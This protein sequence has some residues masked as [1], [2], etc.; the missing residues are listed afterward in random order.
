[1]KAMK[2]KG[3]L[4]AALA[5]ILALGAVLSACS[6]KEEGS[7]APSAG[8]NPSA[9]APAAPVKRGSITSSAYD[10]GTVPA[11]EGTMENNR[12]TR[13]LNENGPVDVKF[14]AIPRFDS[15]QKYNTLFASGS[16]PDLIFEYDSSY[17]RQ[18]YEQK[19]LLPLDDLIP[20][21]APN[22]N[23]FLEQYPVLKKLGTKSDGKL[24]ELG[25]VSSIRPN[26]VLFIRGDWLKKLNLEVP[27]T[28]EELFSVAKAFATQDPDG[29]GKQDTYGFSLSFVSGMVL[30]FMFGNVFTIYEKYPWYVKDGELLHD[31]ERSAAA[32]AYK[33]KIYDEGLVDKDFLTDTK[34]EK[35]KQDWINGKLGIYGANSGL[36]DK[37]T[38]Q[39]LKKLNPQAELI[40]IALPKTSIGQFAPMFPS[41]I[42]NTAVVNAKAKDPAAVLAYVD[43]LIQEP[44]A[45]T[46]SNGIKGVHYET[47]STGCP[48]PIDIEKNKIEANYQYD[49]TLLSSLEVLNPKCSGLEAYFDPLVLNKTEVEKEFYALRKPA[50]EAYVSKERQL[51]LYTMIDFMPALPQDLQL[52]T[53]NA[54]KTIQDTWVKAIVGGKGYTVDQAV[55]DAQGA[56]EKASGGKVDDW[57]KQWYKENKD[58]AIFTKDIYD[59][60]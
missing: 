30:D 56:W 26:H 60:K 28:D 10:R 9:S 31:W 35:A 39:A 48:Q 8:G 50:Y 44:A 13:W 47:E 15:I 20:K 14:V 3:T 2:T 24:Y 49:L 6:A 52:L 18:L 41:P 54:F 40:P 16:A 36:S 43:F 42:R 22:Y 21:Y 33:K 59:M 19:Q 45:R 37:D 55:K 25:T 1:M 53:T 46:L 58:T 51:P 57:Y 5:G 4:P 38:F 23:K 11:A 29:N 27:K 32:V 7:N 12:Y 17:R 34:G